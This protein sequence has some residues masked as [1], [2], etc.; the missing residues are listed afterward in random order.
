MDSTL[1]LNEAWEKLEEQGF[2]ILYG[3]EEETAVYLYVEDI[4]IKRIQETEAIIRYKKMEIPAI[5]WGKQW[6]NHGHQFYDGLVHVPLKGN[7]ELKLQPGPGFGDF[8]HPTTCLMLIFI[9]SYLA[10]QV[11]I[12][13]GCGS[14]ILSIAAA[15]LGA[16]SVYGIDIDDNALVHSKTNATLNHVE[17]ICHFCLPNDLEM[18]ENQNPYLILMNMIQ[19]EQEVAWNSLPMIHEKK[20]WIITSGI[21]FEEKDQYLKWTSLWHWHLIEEKE[22]EGWSSFVFS[23]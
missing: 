4:E 16:S 14:G 2:S 3:E 19:S 8:S 21:H 6:E 5:D 22:Q 1:T 11:T 10:Q 7:Q 23:Y 9:Q 17:K 15:L 13:I 18:N 20:G 12:D